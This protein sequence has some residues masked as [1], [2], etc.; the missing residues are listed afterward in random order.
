MGCRPAAFSRSTDPEDDQ[1]RS[2]RLLTLALALQVHCWLQKFIGNTTTSQL[3]GGTCEM[4]VA[5]Q[6]QLHLSFEGYL[7]VGQLASLAPSAMVAH[8]WM[9]CAVGQAPD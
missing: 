6:R 4:D 1:H 3:A 8:L 7:R 2:V 5:L 9:C